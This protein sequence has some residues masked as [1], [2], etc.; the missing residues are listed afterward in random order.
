MKPRSSTGDPG[1]PYESRTQEQKD[2]DQDDRRA[3]L[4]VALDRAHCAADGTDGTD[5]QHP[6]VY[7]VDLVQTLGLEDELEELAGR[8]EDHPK[9]HRRLAAARRQLQAELDARP[10]E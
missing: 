1:L 2:S 5:G 3:M 6:A 8:I 10:L 4:L 9:R 7:L